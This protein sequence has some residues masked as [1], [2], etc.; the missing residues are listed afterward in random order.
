MKLIIRVGNKRDPFNPTFI[1]GWRDGQIID[2]RPDDYQEGRMERKHFLILQTPHDYWALR[3]STDWKSNKDSVMDFKKF[4]VPTDSNGKYPWEFGYLIDEKAPRKRD[5]FVDIE[6]LLSDKWITQADHDG[7]RDFS[8]EYG[9]IL[10]DR[11]I[12]DYLVHEDVKS[13]I[14]PTIHNMAVSTGTFSIGAGLD[15]ATVTAFEADIAATMTGNLTG[16]HA[17]E[18][19]AI[20]TIVTFDTDTAT[21]LL[22]LTAAPGAKHSGIFGNATHQAGDGARVN[23]GTSDKLFI[24]ETTGGD[25]ADVEI[26]DLVLDIQGS[27]NI[28]IDMTDG[29]DGGLINVKSLVIKGDVLSLNGIRIVSL[30]S[31]G[32]VTNNIIY[33]IGNSSNEIGIVVL[34]VASAQNVLVANNTVVK[35]F[36]NIVQNDNAPNADNYIFKNNLCQ[37][38]T[39]GTDWRDD[40]STFGTTG[41]NVSEDA[42]SPDASY[43]SKDLHTNTIFNGYATDDYTLDSGGDAT[44]LAIVDDGEDLSASFTDD[45]IGQTRS[46]WYIGASEIVAVVGGRIMSSLARDGGLAG[47]GGIA[48]QGG[49]LAG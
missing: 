4:L 48:G 31:N 32:R 36:E 40:G 9:S 15:Y 24:D 39:G 26:S 30:I 27:S 11:P 10:I 37:D 33:G 2:I 7:V 5:W 38:D 17:D 47:A 29:G 3:G 35:C 43:R 8:R 49:G 45:I 19:T 34:N 18:E 13:R 12:E 14:D 6:K 16:E 21:F 20:S 44:N 25:L 28:G 46:T 22:K 42:T 23:Y 41:T 1:Q